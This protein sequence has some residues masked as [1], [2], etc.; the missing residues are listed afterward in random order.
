M[1]TIVLAYHR[2]NDKR[3]ED[4]LTVS[5]RNFEFQLRY[6]KDKGYHAIT[7]NEWIK[8]TSS[9]KFPLQGKKLIITFDDGY[10]DNYLHALPILQKYGFPATV[11]IATSYIDKEEP[12]PW[13][14]KKG[15][16]KFHEEDLPLKSWHILDM[17]SKGL[18]IGSHSVSHRNLTEIGHS[19]ILYELRESKR[20]LEDLTGQTILSF[21][22]PRGF[23]T[24]NI[25]DMVMQCGYN[26]AVVTPSL[27]SGPI[28]S[29]NPYTIRRIGV[30]NQDGITRLLLK[31]SPIGRLVWVTRRF[32][33]LLRSYINY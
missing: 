28:K 29:H 4:A 13:D 27:G 10:R 33:F 6:F 14:I 19:Q 22:Y 18:E 8:Q 23:F 9:L 7:L 16:Q 2:V 31:G 3:R 20:R 11:F 21:C 15:W 32:A 30:Y 26:A 12:F 17:Q 24:Q 5:L 25:C 1:S